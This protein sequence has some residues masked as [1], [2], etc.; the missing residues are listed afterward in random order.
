MMDAS[1]TRRGQPCWY[2][3]PK[4]GMLAIND[5][6]LLEGAIYWLLKVRFFALFLFLLPRFFGTL[7][8]VAGG[9]L[10]SR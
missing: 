4:V 9:E 5:S 1:I 10:E 7:E 3:Q 6:F 8:K 2:R